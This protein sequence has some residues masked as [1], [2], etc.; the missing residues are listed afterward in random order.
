MA[1]NRFVRVAIGFVAALA[2]LFAL[3]TWLVLN[4]SYSSGERAGYL[5]KLSRKGFICKTWEGELQLMA[6]PGAAPEKFIFTVPDS[7]VAQRLNQ[8][9]G[10]RVALT[11]SQHVGVPSSCFGE[12]GYFVSDVKPVAP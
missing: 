2:V 1:G 11:Y 8:V 7:D 4:W 9:M 6:I 10:Q 5:L 12:T 3:Y